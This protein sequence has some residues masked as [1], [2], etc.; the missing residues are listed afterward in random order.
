LMTQEA[1]LLWSRPCSVFYYPIWMWYHASSGLRKRLNTTGAWRLDIS[2]VLSSKRNAMAAYLDA[3]KTSQ[4]YPFCGRLPWA[5]LHNFG[6]DYE[7]YFPASN[8]Q[9][10]FSGILPSPSI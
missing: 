7:V 1:L 3:P 10:P 9:P 5:F 4:G 6:L 2:S 8:F